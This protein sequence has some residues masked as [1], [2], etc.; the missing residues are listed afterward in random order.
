MSFWNNPGASFQGLAKDPWHS[1]Q[2]F[3]TTGLVPLIPYIG[4]IV[5]GIFG[6][7]GGAAAGGAL[8]QEGVDYFS[9]NSEARTGKGILG[10]LTSGAGKGSIANSAYGSFSSTDSLGESPISSLGKKGIGPLSNALGKLG[11]SSSPVSTDSSQDS[12]QQGQQQSL[13]SRAA[14]LRSHI[15]M[16]KSQKA[17]LGGA[18]NAYS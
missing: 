12:T 5:G 4:G 18:L 3:A 16:L 14:E 13:Q 10:S 1:M 2:N 15:A 17:S 8:G 6:G 9:G 7:P 11:N